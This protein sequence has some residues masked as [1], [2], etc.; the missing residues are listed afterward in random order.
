M[1]YSIQKVMNTI[2]Q[3]K[4]MGSLSSKT[5]WIPLGIIGDFINPFFVKYFLVWEK[6]IFYYTQKL[7]ITTSWSSNY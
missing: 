3:H 5:W 7:N 4:V 2:H 1:M 6:Y